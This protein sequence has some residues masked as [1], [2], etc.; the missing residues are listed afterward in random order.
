MIKLSDLIL[1]AGKLW[2]SKTIF[3]MI[4][5]AIIKK[6]MSVRGFLMKED[7]LLFKFNRSLVYC[8]ING[9]KHFVHNKNKENDSLPYQMT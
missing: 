8:V 3:H 2:D 1:K 4:R 6:S 9:Y 5:L 7:D